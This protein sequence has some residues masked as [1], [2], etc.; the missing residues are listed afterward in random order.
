MTS[1]APRATYVSS[2]LLALLMGV[3]SALGLFLPGEYR[4]AEWIRA[5]WF[6]NDWVTLA[7]A[8]P[9]L[10]IALWATRRGSVRGLLLWLGVLGY[11]TYNY[12]YYL[13]GAALNVFFLLYVVTV[14]V[15]AVTLIAMLLRLDVDALAAAF[16]PRTPVRVTGG[17]LVF[18]AAGL[19]VVWVGMWAAYA[20]AG[21][22]TPVEPEAFRLVAALDL[23]LLVSTLA[24]GGTLLW[25]RRPWGY[26]VAPLA[27]VLGALYLLVLSV[28]SVVAIS[29]GLAEA[30]GELPM[31]GP[32]A[33]LTSAA[34]VTLVAFAARREPTAP[35]AA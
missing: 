22:P 30:P 23:T 2:A 33:V 24:L 1:Q 12:A 32:L 14:M 4:D 35:A 34:A 10:V 5:T 17:Y 9:L 7:L 26:V 27:A 6:G 29:R 13:L 19:T 15:A 18:V 8:V 3:Q 28:N 16:S 31:W 25:R 21:R 20:F 11:A